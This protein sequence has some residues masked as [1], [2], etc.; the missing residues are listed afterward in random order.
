M[1]P[2]PANLVEA[3]PLNV[4]LVCSLL[5]NFVIAQ[6]RVW[7]F[8]SINLDLSPQHV[9]AGAVPR[10]GGV[11]I[12]FAMLV[13]G[14]ATFL[15]LGEVL[16]LSLAMSAAAPVF[17]VGQLEDIRGN[18]SP[19]V[20]YGATAVSAYLLVAVFNIEISRYDFFVFDTLIQQPLLSVLLSIFCIAG[21]TQ[22]FNIID[23]KNGLS[24]G[25][26]LLSLMALL[27]VARQNAD[28]EFVAVVAMAAAAIAGFWLVNIMTGRVFL[29]DAGAYLIGFV[30]A[31]MAVAIVARNPQ[32]SPWL[33]FVAA[34]YPI[35]ETLFTMTRRIGF[36]G[37][38]FSEP[39]HLHMHSLIFRRLTTGRDAQFAARANSMTSLILLVVSLIPGGLAVYWSDDS[40]LLKGTV[41]VYVLLYTVAYLVLRRQVGDTPSSV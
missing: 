12:L 41:A 14:L 6:W 31:A 9:H 13:A 19:A 26:A 7:H 16:P 21:V 32:V 23:G 3:V 30:V 24:S 20:R 29:G 1:S 4:G 38:R 8:D 15:V 18:M 34:L 35:T 40:Y 17:V 27:L 36:E 22:S 28:R 10:M 39:D 37:N 2:F 33:P 5:A 11:A 25:M